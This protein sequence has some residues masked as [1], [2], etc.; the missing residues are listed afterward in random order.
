MFY[1]AN[2]G[3]KPWAKL[4]EKSVSIDILPVAG[5]P[6]KVFATGGESTVN[7]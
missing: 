6:V 1:I 2:P 4:T 5:Q 7:C 3:L